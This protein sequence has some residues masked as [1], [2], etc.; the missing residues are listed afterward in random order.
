MT[1]QR[2]NAPAFQVLTQQR[3]LQP[4][5]GAE[6]LVEFEG[7][8]IPR[9]LAEKLK[10]KYKN[11]Y[12]RGRVSAHEDHKANLVEQFGEDA[13]KGL[14]LE[15]MKAEDVAKEIA[16]RQKKAAKVTKKAPAAPAEGE[17]AA[18]TPE[19]MEARIRA[20][21]E[22]DQKKKDHDTAIKLLV[23]DALRIAATEHKLPKHAET[24][25]RRTLAEDYTPKLV[26]GALRFTKEG[27]ALRGDKGFL[28]VAD[29]VA[30]VIKDDPTFA[31]ASVRRSPGIDGSPARGMGDGGQ[32][33]QRQSSATHHD[34]KIGIVDSFLQS[35]G[36]N[37]NGN[38]GI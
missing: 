13:V 16:K 34:R 11:E 36:V 8:K 9:A 17:D 18:E 21:F 26:E 27:K 22:T 3:N 31:A 32:E 29:V 30:Q 28:D 35:E 19:E 37:T 24:H 2:N 6:D 4:P 7:E 20:S 38:E 23:S 25:F 5:D 12:D 10:A 15:N 1:Q 14:D 33:T